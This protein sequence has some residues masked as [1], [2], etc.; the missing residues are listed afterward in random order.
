LLEL[1][2]SG[3]FAPAGWRTWIVELKNNLSCLSTLQQHSGTV[4]IPELEQAL[5]A[6]DEQTRKLLTSAGNL[7]LQRLKA[8]GFEPRANSI[9]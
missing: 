5:N 7:T 9:P 2:L 4:T 8:A 3:G 6:P 1:N